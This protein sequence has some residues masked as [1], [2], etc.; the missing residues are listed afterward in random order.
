[1]ITYNENIIQLSYIKKLCTVPNWNGYDADP[2]PQKVID[3]VYRL[4]RNLGTQPEIFPCASKSIDLEYDR[5][6][7]F[8]SLNISDNKITVFKDYKDRN[9]EEYTINYEINSIVDE[10]QKYLYNTIR[11]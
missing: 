9:E 1:M 11:E 2:I 6:N 8:M 3:F 4:L 5:H 10:V 7:A